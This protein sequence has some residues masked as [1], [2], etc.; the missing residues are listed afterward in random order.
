MAKVGAQKIQ[1]P[2]QPCHQDYVHSPLD[3]TKEK[4]RLI[5]IP[6]RT[7]L[8]QIDCA[9]VTADLALMPSFIGTSN[10][11]RVFQPAYESQRCHTCGALLIVA[12][13]SL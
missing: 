13:T 6:P 10:Q 1:M 4:I 9:I 3:E 2:A 11:R 7:D 5:K 8:D 12:A